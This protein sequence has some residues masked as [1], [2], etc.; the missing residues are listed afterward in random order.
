MLRQFSSLQ[1][2]EEKR[3]VLV[4]IHSFFV[5]FARR[6]LTDTHR[7]YIFE[8]TPEGYMGNDEVLTYGR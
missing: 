1:V 2:R 5:L 7:G 3:R 6:H 8:N 4:F